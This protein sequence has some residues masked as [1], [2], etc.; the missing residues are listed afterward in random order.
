MNNK[1]NNQD[2]LNFLPNKE[3]LIEKIDEYDI[4]DPRSIRYVRRLNRPKIKWFK[5][6]CIIFVILFI[7]I[8]VFLFVSNLT[9]ILYANVSC[10]LLTILLVLIFSRRICI[11][12]IK[13]YQRYAPISIRNRCRFE[14]S[15][16]EY[17]MQAIKKYGT[18]KGLFLGIKRLKRCN[19]SNGGFDYLK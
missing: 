4:N 18:I 5:V 3:M 12:L 15:C 6:F 17:T 11:F 10:V 16:S 8:N 13:I 2:I 7:Y 9:N 19:P 1:E 14:P